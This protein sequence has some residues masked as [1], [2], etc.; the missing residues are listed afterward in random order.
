M[1]TLY[2]EDIFL[3]NLSLNWLIIWLCGRLYHPYP[4]RWRAWLG[5]GLG[6]L[7]SLAYAFFS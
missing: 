5:A 3:L 4:A 7:A 6:A 2:A 1:G